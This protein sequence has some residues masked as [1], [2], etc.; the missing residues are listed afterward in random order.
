MY[1][2]SN[3]VIN[4]VCLISLYHHTLCTTG[5]IAQENT[6]TVYHLNFSRHEE[7]IAK[8]IAIIIK[9]VDR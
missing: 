1:I 5:L 9:Y 3:H 8:K 2:L 7:G 6:S 4:T